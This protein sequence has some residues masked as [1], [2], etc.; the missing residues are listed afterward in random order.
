[1][2]TTMEEV[3]LAP[4]ALNKQTFKPRSKGGVVDP[5]CDAGMS[6]GADASG[7][8]HPLLVVGNDE[9][10]PNTCPDHMRQGKAQAEAAK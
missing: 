1:M 10:R 9:S 6:A 3:L 2:G 4:T 5:E 7:C 8:A